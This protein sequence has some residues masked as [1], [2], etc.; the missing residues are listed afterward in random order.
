MPE[1][2]H[3]LGCQGIAILHFYAND[4]KLRTFQARKLQLALSSLQ[5]NGEAIFPD[6]C[7]PKLILICF[8]ELLSALECAR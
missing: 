8:P 1:T 6:V 5:Q 3:Q 2:K 7:E 4:R